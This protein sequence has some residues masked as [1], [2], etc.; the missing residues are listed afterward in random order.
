MC[1]GEDLAFISGRKDICNNINNVGEV[2]SVEANSYHQSI[3]WK[4]IDGQPAE[5]IGNR[6][7]H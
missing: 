1:G 6:K 4:E 5:R 3:Q 7:W 2:P